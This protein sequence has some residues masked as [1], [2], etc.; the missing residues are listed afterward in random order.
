MV[1]AT[2]NA[3]WAAIARGNTIVV[4]NSWDFRLIPILKQANPKVQVWVYKD[5]SGVRSDDCAT[6]NGEC[7]ACPKGVSDSTYLSSGMGFCWV[8]RHNPD[9]LLRAAATGQPFQFKGYP[10]I[11]ETD[12]GNRPYQRDWVQNVIADVKERGWDGVEVDN[13]L[14]TAGAYGIAAKY[15]TDAAVQAATYAALQE[16]APALRHAGVAS[17]FNVGYATMFPGLWQRWLR[18]V[19]GL[20]QEFYLSYS[21]QP[22]AV[23]LASWAAYEEEISS[24]AVQHKSCWFHSGDYST[25]VT[26]QTSQYALASYLL[27]TDGRQLLAV[28]DMSSGPLAPRWPLGTPLSAMRQLGPARARYF[29]GGIAIANPSEYKSTVYLG[30]S[31]IDNGGHQLSA[32]TLGPASGAVLR[33]APS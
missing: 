6:G 27:A 17:V 10:H 18:Q 8:K 23:G 24:C 4:L 33:T 9:W 19:Q 14:T 30:G 2:T 15:P 29:A 25:A 22:N 20:E 21:A 28:G 31:Y 5:L 7:G 16:V 32:L 26:A 12:Y 3:Q 13:A 1:K 11:W